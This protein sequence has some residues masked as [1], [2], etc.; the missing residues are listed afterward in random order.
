MLQ[1]PRF[2]AARILEGVRGRLDADKYLPESSGEPGHPE[3]VVRLSGAAAKQPYLPNGITPRTK[4]RPRVKRSIL[5][6]EAAGD[7]FTHIDVWRK[8]VADG[9]IASP[10]ET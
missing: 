1:R 9:H 6:Q 10:E 4:T 7:R 8:I 2:T 3:E 5:P